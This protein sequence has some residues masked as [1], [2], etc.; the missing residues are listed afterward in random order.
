VRKET[1]DNCHQEFEYSL[2][3]SVS[4][5]RI[6]P[7]FYYKH[8]SVYPNFIWVRKV[9]QSI[10]YQGF[11]PSWQPVL[12]AFDLGHSKIETYCGECAKKLGYSWPRRIKKESKGVR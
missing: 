11:L 8:E 7:I 10:E 2:R 4:V 5:P 6:I 3:I 12:V 9:D 1:C